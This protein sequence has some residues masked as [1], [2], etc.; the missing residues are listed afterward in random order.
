MTLKMQNFPGSNYS[1]SNT[2]SVAQTATIPVEQF[3]QQAFIRLR[4]R[5]ATFKIESDR[6]GTRWILGSPRIEIQ[7]DGRR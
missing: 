2:A 7:P 6:L 3:T 1:Q 5:Q 4:G